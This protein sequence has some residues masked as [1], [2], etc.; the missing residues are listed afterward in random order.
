VLNPDDPYEVPAAEPRFDLLV[1]H[2]TKL[3]ILYEGMYR[4]DRRFVEL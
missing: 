1:L 3:V 4:K 2:Y